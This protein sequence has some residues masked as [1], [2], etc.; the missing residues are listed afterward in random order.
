MVVSTCQSTDGEAKVPLSS[1]PEAELGRRPLANSGN[2]S[3]A[4]VPRPNGWIARPA[5]LWDRPAHKVLSR[6]E[7][8]EAAEAGPS[9]F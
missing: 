7:C 1:A 3:A 4:H 5:R 8:F 2:A 6:A 9:V